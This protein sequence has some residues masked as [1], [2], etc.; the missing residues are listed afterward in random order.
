MQAQ[1]EEAMKEEKMSI[2]RLLR[3]S[4]YRQQLFV[5][6]M[7]HFSQQFSGINAVR[8]ILLPYSNFIGEKTTFQLKFYEPH[9]YYTTVIFDLVF[10]FFLDL[11]LLYFDLP[12]CR[13]WSACVCH[14]WSG[15]CKHHFHPS[16]G[17]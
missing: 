3:S 8:S 6:L 16:V 4:V 10:V 7:M 2:L 17:K 5:A 14:Y 11:L 12:D 15:S 1:K 13:G 9:Y